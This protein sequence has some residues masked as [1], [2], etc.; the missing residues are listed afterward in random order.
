[1]QPWLRHLTGDNVSWTMTQ[2]LSFT[3][4]TQGTA[5]EHVSS[6]NWLELNFSQQHAIVPQK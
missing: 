3:V 4:L 1:M 5:L 6:S 2:Y